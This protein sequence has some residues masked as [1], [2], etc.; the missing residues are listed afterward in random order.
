[1]RIVCFVL[2]FCVNQI[3]ASG[4]RGDVTLKHFSSSQRHRLRHSRGLE[5]PRRFA[6]QTATLTSS[7]LLANLSWPIKRS[8]DLE[9]DIILGEKSFFLDS[10]IQNVSCNRSFQD[11]LFMII[12]WHK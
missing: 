12:V 7:P 3:F 6:R 9:G 5:L 1:M 2:A 8:V 4:V 10:F 11:Y